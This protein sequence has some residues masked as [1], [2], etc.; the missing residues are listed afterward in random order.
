MSD[1]QPE[2]YV[3]LHQL[4]GLSMLTLRANLSATKIKS[5]IKKAT[6]LDFPKRGMHT[7]NGAKSLGWMSPDELL[8]IVDADE[9]AQTI[10]YLNKALVGHHI[11][12]A[13]MSDART[14]FRLSGQNIREVLAKLAPFDT[15]KS[16]F[17]VGSLVRTRFAQVAGAAFMTSNDTIELICFR[18]VQDYV[19]GLLQD[20]SQ[21]GSEVFQ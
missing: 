19:F 2:G 7:S 15:S 3:G 11:L 12:L 17:A 13:D 21:P 8:I 6:G 1:S 10:E 16:S 9:C 14:M 5:G 20:A 4:R 18:S